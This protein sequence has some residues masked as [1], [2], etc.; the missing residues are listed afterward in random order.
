VDQVDLYETLGVERQ[1]TS[2]AVRLAYRDL[3]RLSH[4]SIDGVPPFVREMELAV[5]V[6]SDGA[7]R[8]H[9]DGVVRGAAGELAA[10]RTADDHA[11][12]ADHADDDDDAADETCLDLLRDF[13]GGPPSREEVRDLFRC[14]FAPG[15][16][17]K[18]GRLRVL[19]LRIRVAEEPLA[20]GVLCLAVPLF[21]AC[22]GC[23][24]TGSIELHAC[25]A[26]G[27][28]G[29][30]ET[31]WLV[32]VPLGAGERLIGLGALGVRTLVL[33]MQVAARA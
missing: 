7:R 29:L 32:R 17:P 33:R 13:E 10:A 25:G 11:A 30:A 26:C 28:C 14:N 1:D 20:P 5:A 18:S 2:V 12:D 9:Y 16:E 15:A 4:A 8:L 23:H 24:G 27:A 21:R 22:P 19:D 3:A 6:L 31:R